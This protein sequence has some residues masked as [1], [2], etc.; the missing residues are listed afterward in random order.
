MSVSQTEF[1][2]ALLDGSAATP[3][4]LR[5]PHDGPAG[6]RFNVYRNNVAVSLTEALESGFPVT[7]KLLGDENFKGI[8]GIYLRQ[9]PPDSPMMMY[10]GASFPD[11]LRGFEPLR[12]I[13]YL[14]DVAE[15]EM[16]Q[17]RAYHAADAD[18]VG[19]DVL[20]RVPADQLENLRLGLAPSV[21]LVRSPW[22]IYDIWRFN[23]V[24]GA[25]KPR[26]EAQDVLITRPDYDPELHLLPTGGGVFVAALQAGDTLGRAAAQASAETADF[27]L[28]TC[29]ALLLNSH[30]ITSATT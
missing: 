4:G 24:E 22:P 18:P 29:L 26:A 20:A 19:G 1:R 5:D 17:R 6:R 16:A 23:M 12:H 21:Q 9:S 13:G 15:L 27:D 7:H 10:Y 28:S 25:P 8:S 3:E 2:T 30:A 11:F 14:G